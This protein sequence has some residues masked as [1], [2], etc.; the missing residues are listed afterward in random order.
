MVKRGKER[1]RDGEGEREGGKEGERE[2]GKGRGR[3]EEKGGS[4][5]AKVT[6]C[7]KVKA[8]FICT[9]FLQERVYRPTESCQM[10][11]IDLYS[12]IMVILLDYCRYA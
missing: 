12:R 8:C 6:K 9:F 7:E 4:E 5:L 1:E 11:V 3:A 10:G 2:G